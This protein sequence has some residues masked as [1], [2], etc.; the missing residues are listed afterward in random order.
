[1]R[2]QILTALCLLGMAH[3]AA[4]QTTD[5][6]FAEALSPSMAAVVKNMHATI[7]RNIAEAA[8]AMPAADCLQGHATSQ[9]LRSI[10]RPRGQREFLLLFASAWRGDADDDQ[11]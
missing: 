6:G 4:A 2:R 7:R 1:M 11:L 5:A 9:K 10:D 3:T 8:E